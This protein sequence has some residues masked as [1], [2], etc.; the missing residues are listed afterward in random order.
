MRFS[1]YLNKERMEE[2]IRL[3]TFYHN[4]NVKHI[5]RQVGFG[6]NPQY[7]SQVFKRYTGLPPTEYIETLKTN[8]NHTQKGES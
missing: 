6:S 3:M 5:A 1:D 8:R 2:A 4:D 7:F